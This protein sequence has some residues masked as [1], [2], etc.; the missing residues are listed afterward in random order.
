HAEA[1]DR[2]LV[3]TLGDVRFTSGQ[4]DLQVGATSNLNKLVVFLNKYPDRSIMIIGHTDNQGSDAYNM[5]LSQRRAD[6][7][8]LYLTQLGIESQRIAA[9]AMG[10]R[11]PV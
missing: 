9:S 11:Q 5:D 4:A 6:S 3:L 7:V 1:T 10:G 2:G 8:E